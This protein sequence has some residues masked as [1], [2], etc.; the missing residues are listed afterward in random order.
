MAK[1]RAALPSRMLLVQEIA[2]HCQVSERTVW[3][4]IRG[5]ELKVCRFGRCTRISEKDFAKFLRGNRG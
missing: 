1:H 5:G 4:W 3:R 2:D